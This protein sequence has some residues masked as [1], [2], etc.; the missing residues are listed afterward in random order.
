MKSVRLKIILTQRKLWRKKLSKYV[1]T[2]DYIDKILILLSATTGGVRIVS[3]ATVVNA[4][5]G[6]ASTG[7]TIL[8]FLW[9]QE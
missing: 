2:F 4:P 3:H 1:T 7:F 8:Y 9:Q 5:V 6:V